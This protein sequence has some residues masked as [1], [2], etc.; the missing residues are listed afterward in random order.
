MEPMKIQKPVHLRDQVYSR[1][2][3]ALLE[4]IY[5][6]GERVT[7]DKIAVHLGV[8]RTPVREALRLL[9]ELGYLDSRP[10]GGFSVPML[11]EEN[12]VDFIKV[13]LLL[14]P[15]AAQEA[16]KAATKEQLEELKSILSQA[17]TAATGSDV[18]DFYA[19][20]QKF[21]DRFWLMSGSA[22]LYA[23]L[24]KLTEQYHYQYLSVIALDDLAVRLSLVDL[25]DDLLKH[26][27][28]RDSKKSV[29]VIKTHLKFKKKELLRII[30]TLNAKSSQ[31]DDDVRN[32]VRV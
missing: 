27:T 24:T 25:L 13:R 14:E 8:S 15:R 22:G 28:S 23:C 32:L 30:D 31:E 4:G 10:S 1:V 9:E 11:N 16:V 29:E 17:R 12:I 7:E 26:L 21:W 3:R 18:F 6:Q 20:V 19:T 5:S 2:K